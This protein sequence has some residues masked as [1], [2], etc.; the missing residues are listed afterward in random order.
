MCETFGL[1]ERLIQHSVDKTCPI[2]GDYNKNIAIRNSEKARQ[3]FTE[4]YQLRNGVI[5]EYKNIFPYYDAKKDRTFYF[6]SRAKPLIK[7]ESGKAEVLF[8]I[9][10]PEA[11]SSDLY[12]KAR[13]D[14]LTG[15]F[16][17]REFDSQLEFLTNIAIRDQRK[18]S[19]I[20]CDIDHFKLYNDTLGHFAGDEC[21]IQIARSIAD[22][23]SRSTDIAC[24][25]GGEEFAVIAYGNTD[26]SRLA[27]S[28]RKEVYI[29]S[30]PHPALNNGPV[31]LSVGYYSTIPSS[32]MT[33]RTIIES[34]DKALYRAKEN[35]RNVCVEY[36]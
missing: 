15:L 31:T 32:A 11:V 10:E 16:N 18:I 19:L 25:Y 26:I 6:V 4:Y 3:I 5:D 7:D 21:L 9:I 35:G 17:R 29:R 13:T 24:R 30:V 2:A 27:E 20:M 22:V 23:C 33:S 8:G 1:N 28:I 34:A 36:Q 12:E 14:S